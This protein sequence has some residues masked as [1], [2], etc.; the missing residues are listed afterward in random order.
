MCVRVV[1]VVTKNARN[2]TAIS[3]SFSL[4]LSLTHTHTHTYAHAH[5]CKSHTC[6]VRM[7][8]EGTKNTRNG[9]TILY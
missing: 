4:S 7:V 2:C 1:T 3:L 9:T 6:M 5:T 8:V